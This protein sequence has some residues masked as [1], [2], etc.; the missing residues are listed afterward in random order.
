[1]GTQWT[2]GMQTRTRF[3]SARNS[4]LQSEVGKGRQQSTALD[5]GEWWRP[6]QLPSVACPR[7][8]STRGVPNTPPEPE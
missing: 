7:Q 6:R 3:F 4:D 1:M 5:Q 8:G 2:W